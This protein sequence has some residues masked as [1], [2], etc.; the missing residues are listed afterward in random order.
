RIDVEVID[1]C[2][3]LARDGPGP[4]APRLRSLVEELYGMGA[5]ELLPLPAGALVRAETA[6]GEVTRA[7]S[8]A[9]RLLDALPRDGAWVPTCRALPA[10]TDALL[11]AGQR[12][13]VEEVLARLT[14][15]LAGCDSPLAP[16]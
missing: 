12:E 6:A 16:A 10:V 8:D 7:A 3:T 9:E 5:V 11:A 15:E 4:A 13:R 2:L 14:D 1:A